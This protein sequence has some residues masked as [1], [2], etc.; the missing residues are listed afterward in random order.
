MV[1]HIHFLE[2][3]VGSEKKYFGESKLPSHYLFCQFHAPQTLQMKK[4]II[5]DVG[6]AHVF[7]LFLLPL[8]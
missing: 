7:E 1:F 6:K 8:L 5:S 3:I 2:K 4:E